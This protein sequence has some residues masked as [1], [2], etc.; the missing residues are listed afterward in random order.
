VPAVFRAMLRASDRL[1]HV[2]CDEKENTT[3]ITQVRPSVNTKM[4]QE[5]KKNRIHFHIKMR[6]KQKFVEKYSAN[7][8]RKE[9]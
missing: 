5:K 6:F 3:A 8:A 7:I 9:F 4:H 2:W 1:T